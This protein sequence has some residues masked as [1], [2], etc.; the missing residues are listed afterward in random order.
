V[1]NHALATL[2]TILSTFRVPFNR[3]GFKKFLVFAA[4]WI[5]IQ[6]PMHCVTEALV[7]TDVARRRHWA[8]YHRLF[9]SGSW[10]PDQ[11]GFW[12]LHRLRSGLAAGALPLVIDDTLCPKKGP[13]VF[14]LGAHV[15]AVRSTR[16]HKVFCLVLRQV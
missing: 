5:L 1:P 14:G 2:L 9:S 7:A 6:G 13:E 8:S 16:K 10:D 11:L 15:D 12:L 4:G 3:R